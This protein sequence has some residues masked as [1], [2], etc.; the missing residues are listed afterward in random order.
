M[1]VQAVLAV[2]VAMVDAGREA[3]WVTFAEAHDATSEEPI[4]LCW[5]AWRYAEHGLLFW[6][7][8]RVMHS[9]FGNEQLKLCKVLKVSKAVWTTLIEACDYKY[10]D[11]LKPSL[12]AAADALAR[13]SADPDPR[14]DNEF[15][16]DEY[17]M[18]SRAVLL[19]LLAEVSVARSSPAKKQRATSIMT[20]FL[21]WVLPVAHI[22]DF[23]RAASLVEVRGDCPVQT[24]NGF[25]IHVDP[26]T[27]YA[28][29]GGVHR[30]IVGDMLALARTALICPSSAGLLRALLQWFAK[31]AFDTIQGLASA[32]ALKQPLL[33]CAPGRL[34][35]VDEDYRHRLM[36]SSVVKKHANSGAQAMAVDDDVEHP[37]NLNRAWIGT[38]TR[39][40]LQSCWEDVDDTPLDGIISLA[41]DGS[42]IGNP[43]TDTV[44]FAAWLARRDRGLWLPCQVLQQADSG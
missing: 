7:A 3:L 10:E 15:I 4:L 34:R 2:G 23:D 31:S 18:D 20:C 40:Y 6:E 44:V 32:D 38:R 11:L 8:R 30:T 42:R 39:T 27:D 1:H 37:Q 9:L 33:R 36:T 25:C 26:T 14:H 19:A 29:E 21:S 13:S 43:A 24:A 22:R 16:R 41:E 12:R 28:A 5:K 17:S 35:R